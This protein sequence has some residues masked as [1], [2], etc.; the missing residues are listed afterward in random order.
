MLSR[1]SWLVILGLVSVAGF[2][3]SC[4][5]DK[6]KCPGIICNNCATDCTSVDPGCGS[7]EEACVGL[8]FFGRDNPDDLRCVYCL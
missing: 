3:V 2:W 5:D 7:S 1:M 4:G 6:D 8:E